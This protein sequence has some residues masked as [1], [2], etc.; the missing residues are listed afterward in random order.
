[1]QTGLRLLRSR[2]TEAG[3]KSP[4]DTIRIKSCPF[5]HYEAHVSRRSK[6]MRRPI[7]CSSCGAPFDPDARQCPY[8][9]NWFESDSQEQG[10]AARVSSSVRLA[11]DFGFSARVFLFAGILLACVLYALGWH[12]ED[13]EYWLADEAIAIWAVALPVWLCFLAFSWKAK[14]GGFDGVGISA[15]F[16]GATLAGWLLGRGLHRMVRIVRARK[17]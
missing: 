8:C 4:C 11:P 14:W 7:P 5:I 9:G 1:M 3:S 16:A 6:A 13:T 2:M 15:M 10:G 12:F 17:Q